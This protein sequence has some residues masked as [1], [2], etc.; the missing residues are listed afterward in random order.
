MSRTHRPFADAVWTN[1]AA[2]GLSSRRRKGEISV[3][4]KEKGRSKTKQVELGGKRRYHHLLTV[5]DNSIQYTHAGD[6]NPFQKIRCISKIYFASLFIHDRDGVACIDTFI[7][8]DRILFHTEHLAE[9]NGGIFRRK[10][11]PS[12]FSFLPALPEYSSLVIFDEI[13][14][15][16]SGIFRQFF[17]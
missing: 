14:L 9:E 16:Q 1:Y 6:G 7:V 10:I 11:V 2:G 5:N 17:H 8:L 3:A 15:P 12:Y 13:I 4:K